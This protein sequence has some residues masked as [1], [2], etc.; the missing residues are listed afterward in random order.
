MKNEESEK[1]YKE[2][3]A[4]IEAV[5]NYSDDDFSSVIDRL[6][7]DE[8]KRNI[9]DHL[10]QL[11]RKNEIVKQYNK[12]IEEYGHRYKEEVS[13][14]DLVYV[15]CCIKICRYNLNHNLASV[16]DTL[17]CI[18][19]ILKYVEEKKYNEEN[20]NLAAKALDKTFNYFLEI[21]ELPFLPDR[22]YTR[23]LI[24]FSSSFIT[25]AIF[26][27]IFF[28][29]HGTLRTHYFREG[30]RIRSSAFFRYAQYKA[31]VQFNSASDEQRTRLTHSLEVSGFA[32]EIALQLGCNWELAE[33]IALGHDV[34]HTPFGHQGEEQLD[35]CLHKHW[36]GRFNHALQSVKVLN[37]LAIHDTLYDR[38]G[39]TGLYLSKP[40]LEGVLKHDT[41]AL[42]HDFLRASWQLQYYDFKDFLDGDE[43]KNGLKTGGLESQI[44]Y[45]SDKI[46]YYAHDW[47]ELVQEG[48]LD[49]MTKELESVLKRMKRLYD[50]KG[51]WDE[52]RPDSYSKENNE[53]KL[54]SYLCVGDT[55]QL[56]NLIN[57]THNSE[58]NFRKSLEKIIDTIN[59]EIKKFSNTTKPKYF[60]E[61]E[62]KKFHDFFSIVLAWIIITETYPSE[63]LKNSNYLWIF[64]N[65]L[66]S[67]DYRAVTRVLEGKLVR[68]SRQKIIK[69]KGLT[70][71][72]VIEF[73]KEK[74]QKYTED[75]LNVKF[76]DI[77]KIVENLLNVSQLKN[78]EIKMDEKYK[79]EISLEK[80][81]KF[82]G[83]L[84]SVDIVSSKLSM[85]ELKRYFREYLQK[86]MT[87]SMPDDKTAQLNFLTEF[88]GRYYHGSSKV[89]AMKN[90]AHKIVEELFVFHMDR[91]DMLPP[92]Y[93]LRIALVEQRLYS[94]KHLDSEIPLVVKYLTER[95]E[96]NEYLKKKCDERNVCEKLIPINNKEALWKHISKK[97][98]KTT[99]KGETI[100][101]PDGIIGIIKK[102]KEQNLDSK[103]SAEKFYLELCHYIAKMRVITDYIAT[104]TERA[105]IKKY[106]EIMSSDMNWSLPY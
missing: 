52:P 99:E 13:R 15:Y 105:A 42:F 50:M 58:N 6:S 17:K 51:W 101:L 9:K 48:Y 5:D 43:C 31:Q 19:N 8:F 64:C 63:H 20:P 57:S 18:T 79:V 24:D 103:K 94:A 70:E 33:T 41:D 82:V 93:Q 59:F 2:V 69:L 55:I 1:I 4:L 76:K 49:T 22:K 25:K 56:N 14:G 61:S 87:I 11:E 74:F 28:E 98:V 3:K 65:F 7:N 36:G 54:I 75:S 34:G 23:F 10:D 83:K 66:K 71:K 68:H 30:V 67:I 85:K 73:G 86:S 84:G 78:E 89:R 62:Y 32:K 96:E 21:S 90:K 47:Y 95:Y 39:I 106:D 102:V 26:L 45:W 72:E 60:T 104:M 81:Q 27:L 44:V 88:I 38:F 100:I 16:E 77:H 40:V 35:K 97:K 37:S 91:Q 12:L 29:I 46:A 80:I 53:I 92:E